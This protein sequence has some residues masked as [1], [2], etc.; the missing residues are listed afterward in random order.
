MIFV[1]S[2]SK[3]S[4]Y[5]ACRVVQK[6][7]NE[8]KRFDLWVHADLFFT[9]PDSVLYSIFFFS[10]SSST[11][12]IVRKKDIHDCGAVIYNGESVF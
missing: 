2:K 7:E 10:T 3:K 12:K 6:N 4:L 8:G 1:V 11:S 5:N 9:T